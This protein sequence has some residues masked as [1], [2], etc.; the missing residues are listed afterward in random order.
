MLIIS[1]DALLSAGWFQVFRA[2]KSRLWVEVNDSENTKTC[3]KNSCHRI[4]LPGKTMLDQ[5]GPNFVLNL[6]LLSFQNSH[7]KIFHWHDDKQCN[8][9][10]MAAMGE[11]DSVVLHMAR[12]GIRDSFLFLRRSKTEPPLYKKTNKHAPVKVQ[13]ILGFWLCMKL[14]RYFVQH[15]DDLNTVRSFW[16]LT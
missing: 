2:L 3:N 9:M 14:P 13:G 7:Q 11:S 1:S 5:F 15:W 16:F 4:C 6:P 10:S 8:I 12:N